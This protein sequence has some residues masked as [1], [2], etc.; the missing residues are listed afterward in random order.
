MV[1]IVLTETKFRMAL[2]FFPR[3][4]TRLRARRF[5]TTTFALIRDIR[6]SSD[7]EWGDNAN[8]NS[9]QVTFNRRMSHGLTYGIAY[10][11]AKALD[12]RK[13]TTYVPYSLTYGPSSTDMRHRLLSELGVGITQDEHTPG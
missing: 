8:Y 6:R 3:T 7:S 11:Y 10:T 9:L 1:P 2:N 5:R 12:D 13:S 4:K